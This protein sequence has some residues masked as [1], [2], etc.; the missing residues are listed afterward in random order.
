MS[1]VPSK[2]PKALIRMVSSG[3]FASFFGAIFTM[4]VY[5]PFIDFRISIVI[6]IITLICICIFIKNFIKLGC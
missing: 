2:T 3:I 4:N 1:L 5:I 6:G